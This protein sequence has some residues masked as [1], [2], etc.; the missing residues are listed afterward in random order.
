MGWVG[1]DR[2]KQT[3]GHCSVGRPTSELSMGWVNPWFGS[4]WVEIFQFLV[5]WGGLDP[6]L[7]KYRK[8]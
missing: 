3:R 7:Q 6:L 8:I 4:G 1:S 2:T 5:G